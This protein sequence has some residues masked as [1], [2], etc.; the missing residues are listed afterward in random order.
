[1]PAGGRGPARR[2]ATSR[3]SRSTSRTVRSASSPR[4]RGAG[5]RERRRPRR[6]ATPP[7]DS[8]TCTCSSSGPSR[9]TASRQDGA[10]Q[11][12]AAAARAA[13]G[14]PG[15]ALGEVELERLLGLEVGAVDQPERAAGSEPV[16]PC[17]GRSRAVGRARWSGSGGRHGR[18]GARRRRSLRR[19]GDSARHS[20]ARSLCRRPVA[21]LGAAGRGRA[22]P[23]PRG[24]PRGRRRRPAGGG[25]ATRATCSA[26]GVPLP[27]RRNA[28]PGRST[29]RMR[30]VGR[31]E[32]VAGVGLVGGAQADPQRAVGPDLGG[33]HAA[34]PLGGQD[35]VHAEGAAALGDARPGPGTNDGQLLGERG[36]LVDDDD[37]PG[38]RRRRR[39]GPRCRR[40]RARPGSA[41]G[42]SARRASERRARAV[43][44]P[45][46]SVTR[47]TV[48]GSAAASA[49]AAPPL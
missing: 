7:P 41:R 20:R 15:A 49:N 40:R 32:D 4:D 44:W 19:A 12:G 22:R 16:R 43:V 1:M 23:G 34:G 8:M 38:Q 25:P 29:G 46:R 9:C 42:G 30:G 48:C 6:P 11:R 45:S 31:A 10:E 35:E 33:D 2:A 37:Q 14:Q 18:C 17:A 26:A 28:R 5:V 47:P 27:D 24:G 3:P 13:D 39:A 36:E 21:A